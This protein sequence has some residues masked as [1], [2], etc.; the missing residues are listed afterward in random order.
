MTYGRGVWRR[1][2]NLLAGSMTDVRLRV[3]RVRAPDSVLDA[4]GESGSL[5]QERTLLDI[6]ADGRRILSPNLTFDDHERARR[7]RLWAERGDFRLIHADDLDDIDRKAPQ[8]DAVEALRAVYEDHAQPSTSE[9][10]EA[11]ASAPST[12]LGTIGEKEFVPLRDTLLHQ[13]EVS[14]FHAEQAQNLLGMLIQ[15]LSLIHI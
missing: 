5:S 3:G 9:Q 7:M 13:L 4:Y 1:R 11:Q 10:A 14:L 12:R 2:E 15:N 8:V 6:Q